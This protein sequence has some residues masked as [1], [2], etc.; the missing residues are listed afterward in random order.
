MVILLKLLCPVKCY[1]LKLS[2][3]GRF[4]T[5]SLKLVQSGLCQ[6]RQVLHYGSVRFST[7]LSFLYYFGNYKCWRITWIGLEPAAFIGKESAILLGLQLMTQRLTN[8]V[9]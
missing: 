8:L 4:P 6:Y 3:Y 9:N 2:V 7:I 5:W 1:H